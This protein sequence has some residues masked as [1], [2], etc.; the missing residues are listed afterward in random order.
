MIKFVRRIRLKL[1]DEGNLKRYLFYAIGEIALVVIGILIALQINNW[2]GQR[3]QHKLEKSTLMEISLA[4]ASD[5][6]RIINTI[7]QLQNSLN[8]ITRLI[9]HIEAKKPY[10]NELSDLFKYSYTFHAATFGKNNIAAFDLLKERGTDI[11]SN[12][13]LRRKIVE[14]YTTSYVEN[15]EWF[16]NLKNVHSLEANRIYSNFKIT[17][18]INEG[19]SMYPYDYNELLE[20]EKLMYPFHHYKS[21]A[22]NGIEKLKVYLGKTQKVLQLIEAE[23]KK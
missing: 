9:D 13:E 16:T 19:I 11:I 4:L 8:N 15:E 3:V 23:L 1:L 12:P 10:V 2:N 22:L 5:T 21:L 7:Q 18:D 14:H 17:G 20:N 6:V